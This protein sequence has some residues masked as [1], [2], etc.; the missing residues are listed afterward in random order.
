MKINKPAPTE[1]NA[2]REISLDFLPKKITKGTSAGSVFHGVDVTAENFG[3]VSEFFGND[4][5][6][7]K[8]NAV[9]RGLC[10]AAHN[11]SVDDDTG[12]LDF[13]KFQRAILNAKTTGASMAELKEE[14]D[15]LVAEFSNINF[16]EPEQLSRAMEI[17]TRLKELKDL[18]EARKREPR[19]PRVTEDDGNEK[20][21]AT[22]NA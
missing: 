20:Q 12:V 5:I 1:E 11:D 4:F 6:I 22:A 19:K 13:D 10:I 14:Q 2:N 18:M 21:A 16:S 9:I 15:V 3:L 17:Q 7:A 8:V